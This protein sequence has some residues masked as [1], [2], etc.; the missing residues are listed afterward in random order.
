MQKEYRTI[1]EVVGPLLLVEGVSGVTYDELVE[2]EQA[3]G[4]LRRGKVLEIDGDE[5]K[6]CMAEDLDNARII[7]A[8]PGAIEHLAFG[9][10]LLERH[11]RPSHRSRGDG[12]AEHLFQPTGY[13]TAC[14]AYRP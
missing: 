8:I 7:D 11:L 1:R 6:T 14:A 5:V 3:S 10:L 4:E 9:K 2:I 13:R 12:R